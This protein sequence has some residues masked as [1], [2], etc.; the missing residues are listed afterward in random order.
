MRAIGLTLTLSIAS[1]LV[2]CGGGGS[3]SNPGSSGTGVL[4]VTLNGDATAATKVAGTAY[5][6]A[7]Y[8]ND[9]TEVDK[10][11]VNL[12]SGASKI[13][14]FTK[15]PTG[16]LRLHVGVSTISGGTETGAVDTF[17][18]GNTAAQP[19]TVSAGEAPTSVAVG[20]S[21]TVVAQGSATPLYASARADGGDYV[22]T[23]AAGWTWTSD[24]TG[25]AT[26]GATGI[27]SGLAPGTAKVSAA[28]GS[29]SGSAAVSVTSSAVY[30][31]KWT[32]MVYMDA[33]ND[34][35]SYAYE[36]ISQMNAI[37]TNPNVR[38]VIQW[39]QVKGL[40]GNTSPSFSGTRRY[41]AASSADGSFSP[42]LV[43]DLGSGVDMASPT[44]L[45]DFVAWTKAKYPADH[46]ALVLW[47]HG[48][49]WYSTRAVPK[50]ITLKRRAI[51][52]DEESNNYLDFP[53]VRGALDAGALDIL[54]YDACLMQ[55]AESLLEFS[56]RTKVIVGDEDDVPGAGY[57]YHLVFKPFVDSPD[58]DTK[59]L[60]A[61]MVSAFANYYKDDSN[62]ANWPIQLSALDC[63]KASAVASALD[64]LGTALMNE[65][66][67]V[68][69]TVQKVRSASTRIEPT[70]GYY[71]YDLDQ[72]ATNFA[73]Q[74]SLSAATRSAASAL[75]VAV[76]SATL[77]NAGGNGVRAAPD[78][79]GMSID[80]STSSFLK[81]YDS[82][83][84]G[85]PI[86][87]Y[88][89]LQLST[90]THWDEF[91]ESGTAN[92]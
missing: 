6:V 25:V 84:D 33:A 35:W 20:P 47:S 88:N 24:T 78:D 73:A 14:N 57:P 77:A 38:F 7:V 49:G 27:V 5:T 4:A 37:A 83:N 62:D 63:S 53:D 58:S 51:I 39:K 2:G 32:V 22:L 3:H 21:P 56:D 36:N 41:V 90:L 28:Y 70:V 65:G 55:G 16:T 11:T 8:R 45:H 44:A 71:F 9:G 46:Y 1:L 82:L 50:A 89:H 17:F 31:G 52:Y 91:L 15:L 85:Y 26:V 76:Q 13:V 87:G 80:F 30:Q 23:P 66:S 12:S 75:S 48:G 68:A 54:A 19:V 43:G 61:G 40:D 69:A 60:A 74:T 59:T 42:T 10:K 18:A 79:H 34:L 86:T 72:V 81:T 29:L 64:G 67:S 92:P